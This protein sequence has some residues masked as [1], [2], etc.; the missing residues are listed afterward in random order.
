[1]ENKKATFDDI[2]NEVKKYMVK[3]ENIDLITRAYE[4]ASKTAVKVSLEKSGEP[5]VIHVIQVGYILAT[6]RCGPQTIAAELFMT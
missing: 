5:Y 3:P 4:F 2:M 6:L 1:M